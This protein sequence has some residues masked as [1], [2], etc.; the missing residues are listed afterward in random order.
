[1]CTVQYQYNVLHSTVYA[2]QLARLNIKQNQ[3]KGTQYEY[4]DKPH[5]PKNTVR[6]NFPK[7]LPFL[8]L[9]MLSHLYITLTHFARKCTVVCKIVSVCLWSVGFMVCLS[10]SPAWWWV[11][12]VQHLHLHIHIKKKVSAIGVSHCLDWVLEVL[13]LRSV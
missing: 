11:V 1:M 7:H 3:K 5:Q 12:A 13:M 9:E 6:N 10:L 8:T 4:M 2:K